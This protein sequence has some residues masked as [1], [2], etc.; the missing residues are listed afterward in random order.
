MGEETKNL[1]M[2]NLKALI[3]SMAAP[4]PPGQGP[5]MVAASEKFLADR[6]PVE[7]VTYPNGITVIEAVE[8][9]EPAEEAI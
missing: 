9:A 1:E 7:A 8:P 3:A 5:S 4:A 6:P 2:E